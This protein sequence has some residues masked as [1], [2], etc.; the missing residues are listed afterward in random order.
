[1]LPTNFKVREE[2]HKHLAILFNLDASTR[3]D[4]IKKLLNEDDEFYSYL[5]EFFSEAF[6][7]KNGKYLAVLHYF[8]SIYRVFYSQFPA[9]VDFMPKLYK[10]PGDLIG[11]LSS[12]F[13]TPEI[14]TETEN[15]AEY[16]ILKEQIEEKDKQIQTLLALL[17][18]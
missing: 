1:M 13:N 3:E 18:K 2:C 5:D 12:Y 17:G 15:S 6:E 8:C 14:K 7:E 11:D 10:E 4:Y 16:R 9:Y